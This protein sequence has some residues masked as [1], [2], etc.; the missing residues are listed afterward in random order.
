MKLTKP[1][2]P[3]QNAPHGF[4]GGSPSSFLRSGSTASAMKSRVMTP[5]ISSTI[6]SDTT[7]HKAQPSRVPMAAPGSMILRML[8]S[9]S[10]R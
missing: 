10:R 1:E 4:D 3:P 6:A 5:T 9:A 7:V 2:A 8:Q